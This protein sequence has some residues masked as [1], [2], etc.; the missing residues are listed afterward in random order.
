MQQVLL[1]AEPSL[2]PHRL[3]LSLHRHHP[4]TA[5]LPL[6]PD[7]PV[8]LLELPQG[9]FCEK[10]VLSTLYHLL[11]TSKIKYIFTSVYSS[12][13]AIDFRMALLFKFLSNLNS[14]T[15]LSLSG[16]GPLNNERVKSRNVWLS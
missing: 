3:V 16:E 11:V 12:R 6:R 8:D 9:G 1:T 2:Q 13:K 7:P 14:S 15:P 5:E 4:P 10:T